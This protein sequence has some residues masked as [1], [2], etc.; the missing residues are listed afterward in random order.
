MG[1]KCVRC[2]D[3]LIRLRNTLRDISGIPFI[4]EGEPMSP[5]V[6]S[7]LKYAKIYAERLRDDGCISEESYRSLK[8]TLEAM[9]K[10]FKEW[11]EL[12]VRGRKEEAKDVENDIRLFARGLVEESSP[13]WI[14]EVAE[15]CQRE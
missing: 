3:T 2:I 9:Q 13:K 11:V 12:T 15:S 10:D 7:N 14:L 1:R 8:T 4:W 5:G 6:E